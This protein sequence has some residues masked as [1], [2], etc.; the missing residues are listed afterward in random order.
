MIEDALPE[1]WNPHTEEEE[2]LFSGSKIQHSEKE[3]NR[4]L[5]SSFENMKPTVPRRILT[6]NARNNIMGERSCYAPSQASK[7]EIGEFSERYSQRSTSGMF[8]EQGRATLKS[9]RETLGYQ[10]KATRATQHFQKQM[11]HTYAINSE[12]PNDRPRTA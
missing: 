9:R 6:K 7:S 8:F 3:R 1:L 11:S 2:S 12:D 10:E 5:I 4:D